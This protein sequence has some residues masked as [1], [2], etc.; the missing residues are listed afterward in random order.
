MKG[1]WRLAA[2][3]L[4]VGATALTVGITTVGARSSSN[5]ITY[6]DS[7]GED[8]AALDIKSVVVSN[9]DSGMLSFAIAL[10]NPPAALTGHNDVGVYIDTDNNTSDGAGADYAGAELNFEVADGSVNVYKW[11]GTNFTW[12]GPEPSSLIYSY[13]GGVVTIR[14]KASD[15]SL[16]TFDFWVLTDTDYTDP[17]SHLD[18]APDAGRESYPFEVKITPP[19]PAPKPVPHKT[20]PKC[21][22]GHH[23]TKAHP[24]HK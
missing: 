21:K 4:I 15:V 23:S 2:V 14:V 3:T 19:A 24:C 6:Q 1:F 13:T 7:V 8:S 11:D 5:S 20:I 18:A 10:A 12:S 17:H 16:G 22:K 9:D